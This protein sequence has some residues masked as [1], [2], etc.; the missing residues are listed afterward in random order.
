LYTTN[1]FRSQPDRIFEKFPCFMANLSIHEDEF[2]QMRNQLNL[3]GPYDVR[4]ESI[5]FTDS[6][7]TKIQSFNSIITGNVNNGFLSPLVDVERHIIHNIV[8]RGLIEFLENNGFTRKSKLF[9]NTSED[10]YIYSKRA[11]EATYLVYRGFRPDITVLSDSCDVDIR[12]SLEGLHEIQIESDQWECWLGEEVRATKNSGID[13]SRIY[14]LERI[15]LDSEKAVISFENRQF[16]ISLSN[17]YV[18]ANSTIL[19]KRSQYQEM[20]SFRNFII[21]IS[22]FDFLERFLERIAPNGF[23]TL[24]FSELDEHR[25]RFH[26]ISEEVPTEW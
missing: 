25:I 7:M 17:L 15:N 19:K 8:R 22:V 23:L 16:E 3:I 14:Y 24:E 1:H 6:R 11:Q 13:Q 26:Q 9:Y 12:F 2:W 4:M 5:Y 20:N 18:P 21:G 10:G